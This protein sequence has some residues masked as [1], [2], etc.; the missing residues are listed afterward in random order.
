MPLGGR[1]GL[2]KKGRGKKKE[3]K[4]K[5]KKKNATPKKLSR[6][7]ERGLGGSGKKKSEVLAE[8]PE[9]WA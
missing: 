4:K 7:D 8:R 3:K 2:S 1:Q 9:A 6:R 5:K